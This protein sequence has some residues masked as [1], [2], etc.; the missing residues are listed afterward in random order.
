MNLRNISTFT[1]SQGQNQISK[2]GLKHNL[3]LVNA[4]YLNKERHRW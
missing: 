3:L 1:D 2:I 4:V